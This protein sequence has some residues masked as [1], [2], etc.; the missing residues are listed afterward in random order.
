MK[1]A[2]E[3]CSVSIP[4]ALAA[5][6][7][8]IAHEEHRQ[9]QEVV[10]EAVERYLEQRRELHDQT[11]PRKNLVQFLM[12]STFAGAELDLER[13]RDYARPPEL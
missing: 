9:A 1:A 6:V 11:A 8:A 2:S 10:R 4:P 7:E 3:N 5:E 12:E 13:R